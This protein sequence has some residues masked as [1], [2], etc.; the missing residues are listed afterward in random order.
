VLYA[1]LRKA[2]G[3][4]MIIQ[5]QRYGFTPPGGKG[6]IRILGGQEYSPGQARKSDIWLI[7]F[8]EEYA[9]RLPKLGEHE[10]YSSYA[11][12]VRVLAAAFFDG[13]ESKV[14]MDD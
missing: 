14:K 7:A 4:D 2:S 1:F 13:D 5:N 12:V 6:Q 9:H 10:S 3:G 8:P 11:E